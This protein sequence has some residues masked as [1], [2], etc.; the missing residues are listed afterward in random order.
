MSFLTV[1]GT[2]YRQLAKVS[3]SNTTTTFWAL[4]LT[5]G[6]NLSAGIAQENPVLTGEKAASET[7]WRLPPTN[8]IDVNFVGLPV[9]EQPRS[10]ADFHLPP[11]P[12]WTPEEFASHPL[13]VSAPLIPPNASKTIL[14]SPRT[15]ALSDHKDGFFQK[16]SSTTTALAAGGNAGLGI[17]EI[18]SFLTVALPAPTTE[19]PLLI[20]SGFNMRLLTGPLTPDLPP[21]LYDAYAEFLW[22][23]AI[24][25]RWLGV[26]GISPGVYSDFAGNSDSMLRVKGTMLLRYDWVPDRWQVAAGLLYLDRFDLTILPVGGIIWIPSDDL[27]LELVFPQSKIAYRLNCGKGWENWAY[28]S[29]E[30]GGDQWSISDNDGSQEDV[31]FRDWRL[32]LGFEQ[33]RHGGAGFRVEVGYVFNRCVEFS[34]STNN[35][36]PDNTVLFRAGLRL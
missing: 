36:E 4:L 7:I 30:F 31:L 28:L 6:I 1:P 18:E 32:L 35:F 25:E 26:L 23:P 14:E 19:W 3:L 8:Q 29:G 5:L 10:F 11:P 27:Q 33:K 22:V 15:Y 13:P 12:D 34:S 24:N 2:T 17:T 16:V 21:Q 9:R 20:S